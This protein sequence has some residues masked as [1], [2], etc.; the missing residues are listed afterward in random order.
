MLRRGVTSSLRGCSLVQPCSRGGTRGYRRPSLLEQVDASPDDVLGA[1]VLANVGV[2]AAWQTLDPSFMAKH[3]TVCRRDLR[4]GRLYTVVTAS[5]SHHDA[6]HAAGNMFSL[7]VFGREVGRLFGGVRLGGLYLLSGIAGNLAHCAWEGQRMEH[8]RRFDWWMPP[9]RPALGA[10]GSVNGIIVYDALLFPTR[11]VYVNLIVPV[12]ALLLA[13]GFLLRDFV[14]VDR[15]DGVGHAA[16]LGGAAAGFA[17][18]AWLRLRRPG[19][20]M[21]G[22]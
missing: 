2:W 20:G 16:H 4:E 1:L 18:F 9:D 13:G 3:F 11:I 5:F 21:G 19:R 14:G 15:N 17:A 7:F 12:P 22:W 8:Q 6:W 10:S